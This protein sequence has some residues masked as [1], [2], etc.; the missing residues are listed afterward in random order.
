MDVF[1]AMEKRHSTRSFDETKEV[2][3]EMVEEL[4]RCA[5]LAPTAG[6]VQPWRF[7]VVR[8]SGVKRALARAA[9]GQDF[10][11][12]APVVIAVY[13]DLDA[14]EASYGKRGAELYSVQDTAAA[15]ENILLAAT[16]LGL[17]CCWV[18]AFLED[19]VSRTLGLSQRQ[20]PLALIPVGYA[21]KEGSQPSKMDFKR[22]TRYI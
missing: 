4:L 9:L 8:D 10:L 7:V 3:E 16:S 2:Q 14:H 19:E 20:R 12:R 18:G 21:R 6:N 5:C 15:A 13:A 11:T 22:L 17:G 1:E